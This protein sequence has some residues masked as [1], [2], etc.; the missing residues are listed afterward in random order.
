MAS[1][2]TSEE[3]VQQDDPNFLKVNFLPLLV[4]LVVVDLSMAGKYILHKWVVLWAMVMV[5]PV[6]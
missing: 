3:I 1:L 6:P 5:V 2:A 4:V